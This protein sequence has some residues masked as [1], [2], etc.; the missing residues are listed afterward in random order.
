MSSQSLALSRL[1][2]KVSRDRAE[3]LL[4]ITMTGLALPRSPVSFL[5]MRCAA[6]TLARRNVWSCARMT[7]LSAAIGHLLHGVVELFDD[8]GLMLLGD[9]ARCFPATDMHPGLVIGLGPARMVA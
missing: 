5:S 9:L 7:P 6:V 2:W 4:L 8:F 1:P 3:P